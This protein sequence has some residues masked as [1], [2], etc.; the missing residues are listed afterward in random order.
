MG[1]W[2]SE[3]KEA[4]KGRILEQDT[5]VGAEAQSC[6][7]TLGNS[8]EHALVCHLRGMETGVFIL[9]LPSIAG[10]GKFLEASLASLLQ[11]DREP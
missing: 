10:R 7:G 1:K 9:R 5:T 2:D 11:V 8:V 6:W 4:N 3:G